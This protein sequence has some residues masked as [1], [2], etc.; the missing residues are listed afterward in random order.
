MTASCHSGLFRG[1]GNDQPFNEATPHR[2]HPMADSI[3]ALLDSAVRRG[4]PGA[5]VLLRNAAG[6]LHVTAGY[7]DPGSRRSYTAET[8]SW[9]FSITK[10]Y[11]A[12]LALQLWEQKKLDLDAPIG[13]I[14][15]KHLLP[16]VPGHEAIT[17]IMLLQHSSGL[18]NFTALPAFIQRQFTRPMEQPTVQERLALL[19]GTQLLFKPGSDY[20]Y[21]NTNYLLLQLVL[22]R[23]SGKDYATLLR[24]GILQPAGLRNTWYAPAEARVSTMG[25]PSAFFDRQG[26]G[27]LEDGT[28]WNSAIG[29]GSEG[30]GGIAARPDDVLRF[31]ATLRPGGP[32][33]SD[34]ALRRMQHWFQGSKSTQPDYGFGI[35]YFQY[36]RNGGAP[37][38]GH[39]GDGLG[40]STLALYVPANGTY[41][42]L[43]VNAGRQLPGPMLYTIT[44][45]KNDLCR[46]VAS[47]R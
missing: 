9:L 7:A 47:Q 31:Y 1:A 28:A 19:E 42:Y 10:T 8:P 5:Q 16:P 26:K 6:T 38:W 11:S 40:C 20:D 24:D 33:L 35:E 34:T 4:L 32:L 46:Y 21:S 12:V 17:V 45:L 37:Q 41:L 18:R 39:E 25:F 15:P 27:Q 23:V 13:T 2:V 44:D 43:N 22:E 3:Q 14:L 30:Y 29:R 36:D